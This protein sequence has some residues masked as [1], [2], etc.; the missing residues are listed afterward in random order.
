MGRRRDLRERFWLNVGILSGMLE[1]VL[2]DS[3]AVVA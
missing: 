2:P 1:L 3:G